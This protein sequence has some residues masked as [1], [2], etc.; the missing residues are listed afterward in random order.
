MHHDIVNTE[1]LLS[2]V[3][4]IIKDTDKKF[5]ECLVEQFVESLNSPEID[6]TLV[7]NRVRCFMEHKAF[8]ML[9]QSRAMKVLLSI[10]KKSLSLEGLVELELIRPS[11]DSMWN[12][13]DVI[14]INNDLSAMT[15]FLSI[16]EI[17]TAHEVTYEW[18]LGKRVYPP[19][20]LV[21]AQ[22]NDILGLIGYYLKTCNNYHTKNKAEKLLKSIIINAKAPRGSYTD[23]F[24]TIEELIKGCSMSIISIIIDIA[25]N[26]PEIAKSLFS[27]A[28]VADMVQQTFVS[29]LR[30]PD[31]TSESYN[32]IFNQIS[33]CLSLVRP[34]M[35]WRTIVERLESKKKLESIIVYLCN[36]ESYDQHRENLMLAF[37]LYPILKAC[38]P[39]DAKHLIER[40]DIDRNQ[41]ELIDMNHSSRL[42]TFC[43]AQIRQLAEKRTS[44]PSD[45]SYTLIF[46]ALVLFITNHFNDS[47]HYRNVM[48]ACSVL[49]CLEAISYKDHLKKIINQVHKIVS[50]MTEH[51]EQTKPIILELMK[52]IRAAQGSL[53]Y[54]SKLETI[55]K[56][57]DL[58]F[59]FKDHDVM[60]EFALFFVNEYLP[61]NLSDDRGSK[62]VQLVWN[63][64]YLEAKET[65]HRELLGNLA[66]LL[67]TIDLEAYKS[68]L[69][70]IGIRRHH[71]VPT[72]IGELL[73]EK[74][75][76]LPTIERI[77][78][79]L[80]MLGYPESN[81]TEAISTG[82]VSRLDSPNLSRSVKRC[83]DK[84]VIGLCVT[85]RGETCEST[86]LKALK[87]INNLI[88]DM[89]LNES[90]DIIITERL[91]N[92]GILETIFDVATGTMYA[93]RLRKQARSRLKF[94]KTFLKIPTMERAL[95]NLW[96]DKDIRYAKITKMVE[97]YQG[98]GEQSG[99]LDEA[100]CSSSIN[101]RIRI[102]SLV[103]DILNY[104]L[105][106]D[107]ILDCY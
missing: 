25:K 40:L 41:S 51:D 95:I 92:N 96:N 76:V 27:Q 43:I 90:D 86:R 75:A 97:F 77:I 81:V 83:L 54:G 24:L 26:H 5:D 91:T 39:D 18:L 1:R 14:V 7:I 20:N 44:R 2:A 80:D 66:T 37:S 12:I 72:L 61:L 60:N 85:V 87:I 93:P 38:K 34:S 98:N 8:L 57:L 82:Y 56:T 21:E 78:D 63:H 29:L 17:L 45:L 102:A 69:D 55:N 42:L 19:I 52:V 71:D 15:V 28:N 48:E 99:S 62:A 22:I 47:S 58:A 3:D 68:A 100:Q 65:N 30:K 10:T 16:C 13:L 79:T 23:L 35:N 31:S 6:T 4:N 94:M 74:S 59:Q 104:D 84:L 89:P 36:S 46:D 101:D 88:F 106:S 9:N 33:L 49:R 67:I 73:I 64:M 70:L 11:L 103:D 32:R 107:G 105:I 50:H 53:K